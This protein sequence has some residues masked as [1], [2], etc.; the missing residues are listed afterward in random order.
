MSS[1]GFRVKEVYVIVTTCCCILI[2]FGVFFFRRYELTI[3]PGGD[4]IIPIDSHVRESHSR[5]ERG[6]HT[7]QGSCPG[8]WSG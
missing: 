1:L 5:G 6:A 4:N 3:C 8:L 2:N 7:G